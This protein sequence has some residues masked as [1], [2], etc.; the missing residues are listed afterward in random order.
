MQRLRGDDVPV[1]AIW[2]YDA[3]D[4]RASFGWPWQI[5]APIAPGPYPDLP[6]MIQR[7]HGQSLK[8]LGYLHPFVYPGTLSYAEAT[9][10]GYLVQEPDDQPYVEP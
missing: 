9:W 1:D 6:G 4:E 3:V 8:V 10:Q 7:L 2:I 5:Y